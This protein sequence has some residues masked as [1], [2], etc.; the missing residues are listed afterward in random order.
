[1]EGQLI[2]RMGVVATKV[3][4]RIIDS[5]HAIWFWVNPDSI[6]G[7]LYP[8]V[9]YHPMPQYPGSTQDF[10]FIWDRK[11]GFQEL[12]ALLD[13]F[14]HAFVERREFRDIFEVPDKPTANYTF[15]Y[16]L[17]SSEQ[18]LS[19]DD[20]DDFRNSILAFLDRH[21]IALQT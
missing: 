20:L 12:E 13:Q 11:L 17:R 3:R 8:S 19:S 5:G 2:G 7:E 16:Y 21:S 14:E 4:K 15:R 18:T 1:M 10:T 6:T 9:P